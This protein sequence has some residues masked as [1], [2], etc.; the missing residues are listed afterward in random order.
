M[1]I[2]I[3]A[4]PQAGFVRAQA[5]SLGLPGQAP[6]KSRCKNKELE[7]L[8]MV[9]ARANPGLGWRLTVRVFRGFWVFRAFRIVFPIFRIFRIIFPVFDMTICCQGPSPGGPRV[10]PGRESTGPALGK[11]ICSYHGLILG[12]PGWGLAGNRMGWPLPGRIPWCQELPGQIPPGI[13]A[14]SLSGIYV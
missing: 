11:V 5:G 8:H 10:G 2:H 9:R 12:Q 1:P 14:G 3:P 7:L 6:V 4:G 13:R